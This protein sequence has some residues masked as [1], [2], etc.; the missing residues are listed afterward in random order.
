MLHRRRR[1][2]RHD[3]R[4][5]AGPRRRRRCGAREAR[6]LPARLPRRHHPPVDARADARARACSTSSCSGRTRRSGELAAHVGDDRGP[7]RR[8][9]APADALPVHRHHAAVGLPRLPR[10]ARR[11]ATRRFH[12]RMEAEVDRPDRGGGT[13][14]RRARR[15]TPD[16]PARGPGRARR[17]RRRPPLDRP[18]ER[19]GLRG[20]G[21][22]RADR[23]AL[24]ARLARRRAT[25]TSRWAGFDRGRIFVHAR[26]RRLL[27]VRRSSSPRAASTSCARAGLEAFRAEVARAR[28]VRCATASASSA[29]GTTSSC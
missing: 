12:L 24:V 17:R 20:R 10:A 23:R 8:L 13:G 26:P 15:P 27:A 16:R 6:R 2:G 3:A 14:R 7:G 11:A 28:A 1:A 22:G 29:T 4:P 5:P 25:P 19:A 21:P 9:H 18:R